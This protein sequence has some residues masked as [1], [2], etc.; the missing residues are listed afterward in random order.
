MYI[1]LTYIAVVYR[2]SSCRLRHVGEEYA[3]CRISRGRLIFSAFSD[4]RA[5][6]VWLLPKHSEFSSRSVAFRHGAS[7]NPAWP[8]S[9]PICGSFHSSL[10]DNCD[11]RRDKHCVRFLKRCVFIRKGRW[12]RVWS[13][14]FAFCWQRG[15]FSE[16]WREIGSIRRSSAGAETARNLQT[17][18]ERS[19]ENN[20]SH[21]RERICRERGRGSAKIIINNN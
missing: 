1:A 13:L 21:R 10:A 18:T 3:E 14:R 9:L 6:D 17:V 2:A 12:V 19:S 5:G 8:L 7:R 20:R 15:I 16:M 11:W 4:C